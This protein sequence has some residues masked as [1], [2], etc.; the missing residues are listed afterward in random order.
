MKVYY[1]AENRKSLAQTV[2]EFMGAEVRYM[3]APTFAYKVGLCIIDREGNLE[4]GDDTDGK[5]VETLLAFLAQKGYSAASQPH[6]AAENGAGVELSA[7]EET[8][9]Q[10]PLQ[11]TEDAGQEESY[12]Q[13]GISAQGQS[14][15]AVVAVPLEKVQM[16]NLDK[17]LA[18]K[19][20]LISKAL[21]IQQANVT[22]SGEKVFFP[23]L[24][25]TFTDTKRDACLRLIEAL[26]KMSIGQKR[27]SAKAKTVENEKYA[28]RCFLLRLGF[29]GKGYK[30]DRKELLAGLEGDSAFKHKREGMTCDVC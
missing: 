11:T 12:P 18:A 5:E 30:A 22:V 21:G 14:V 1:E 15:A 10:Q 8:G 17:I 24:R 28:F 4:I 26:C 16:D 3:A 20:G 25:G 6:T 9:A 27:F 2:S 19:G 13:A 23:W 29:I 7:E